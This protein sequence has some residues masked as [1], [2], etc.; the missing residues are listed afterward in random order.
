MLW[1]SEAFI[2]KVQPDNDYLMA[3][4]ANWRLNAI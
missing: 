3:Y 4:L 1:A 2:R